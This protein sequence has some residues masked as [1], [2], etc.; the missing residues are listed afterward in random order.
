M[1]KD[2]ICGMTVDADSPHKSTHLGRT[3]DF[4]SST[5]KAK[6]DDEV[7]PYVAPAVGDK[8]RTRPLGGR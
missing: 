7:G 4:C 8:D 6:F 1:A 5:C 3:Y 2:L